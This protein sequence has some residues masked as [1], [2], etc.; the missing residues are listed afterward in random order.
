VLRDT[1]LQELPEENLYCSDTCVK[2][3][4]VNI[5]VTVLRAF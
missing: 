2:P 1:P 3:S 4:P 5:P